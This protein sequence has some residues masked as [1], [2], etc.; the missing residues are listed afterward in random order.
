[1]EHN[2]GQCCKQ[3]CPMLWT[4]IILLYL[5][6]ILLIKLEHFVL[7]TDVKCKNANHKADGILAY[8]NFS[9]TLGWGTE[10]AIREGTINVH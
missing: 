10:K 2:T 6:P 8:I 1:L 7:Y 9:D 5:I 3:H 4:I